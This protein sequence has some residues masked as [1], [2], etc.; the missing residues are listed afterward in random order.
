MNDS[1]AK[2]LDDLLKKYKLNI[3]D[4]FNRGLNILN[5]ELDNLGNEVKELI[6]NNNKKEKK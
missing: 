1:T 5:L 4:D 6:E 2:L 3:I